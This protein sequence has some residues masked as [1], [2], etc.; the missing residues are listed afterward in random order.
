MTIVDQST[1][2]ETEHAVR[3]A[4][5]GDD[6]FTYW[7]LGSIGVSRARNAAVAL[8]GGSI[9]AFTD[10]DCEVS[11]DW[12]TNLV[13]PFRT[14]DEVGVIFGEL[15][16]G[17]HDPRKG[18][19]PTYPVTSVRLISSPFAKWREGGVGANMAFRRTALEA[20]GL[21]DELLGPGA[22]LAS[23]EE[24]DMAYRILRSGY[25]LLNVSD[26]HV[27]HHGFRDWAEGATMMRKTGQGVAAAYFKHLRAGD[28]A[29]LPTLLVEG[30]RTISWSHLIRLKRQSGLG[31]FVGYL[32]G[33]C[34]SFRYSVD[35]QHRLY[36]SG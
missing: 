12:L 19:I 34:V 7:R 11:P 8:A 33:I 24:G 1:D 16:S 26:A 20:A 9:I 22:P 5:M 3:L 31:R 15:R 10:D 23:C 4:T 14:F 27:T 2:D 28:I 35:K 21:F 32:S 30:W 6:R 29:I 36:R 18:F 25:A 13:R 17:P